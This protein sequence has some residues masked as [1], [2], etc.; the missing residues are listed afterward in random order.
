MNDQDARLSAPTK[1][2]GLAAAHCDHFDYVPGCSFELR[3]D[4]IQESG[5]SY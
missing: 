4:G 5:I 1:F 2:H 3:K